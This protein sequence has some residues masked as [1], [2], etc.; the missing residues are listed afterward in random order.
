MAAVKQ[1]NENMGLSQINVGYTKPF[2]EPKRVFD[3]RAKILLK[4][5]EEQGDLKDRFNKGKSPAELLRTVL[6]LRPNSRRGNELDGGRDKPNQL[7]PCG[8]CQ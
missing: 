2:R 8:D 7:I 5:M 3:N 6:V 4:E 1:L